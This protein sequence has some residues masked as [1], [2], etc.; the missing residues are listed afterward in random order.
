MENRKSL[1]GAKGGCMEDYGLMAT[2]FLF[3]V[4]KK[5]GSQ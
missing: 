1:P 3:W 2:E 5:Y 4:M